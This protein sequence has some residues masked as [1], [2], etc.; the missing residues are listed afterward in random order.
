MSIRRITSPHNPLVKRLRLLARSRE[1]DAFLVEGRHVLA[2]ALRAGWP[3]GEVLLAEDQW[4]LWRDRLEPLA[5]EGRVF[6]A[7]RKVVRQASALASPEG[8][9]AIAQRR[10]SPW[11][12]TEEGGLWLYLDAVQDPVNVGML[13]R[14]G[15]AFGL[16]GVFCGQGSADPFHPTAL[17]RSA[18]AAFHLPVVP[19]SL[20]EFLGWAGSRRVLLVAANARGEDFR[21]WAPPAAPVV[22]ALGNEGRGLSPPLLEACRVRL[23]I[24]MMRGWDSLNVAVAGGLL[25]QHLAR[26]LGGGGLGRAS[27]TTEG[28]EDFP[29]DSSGDSGA[30]RPSSAF[31][32]N[33]APQSL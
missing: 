9:V 18:G 29:E 19:C 5:S 10:P 26:L 8:V 22:L 2:E 17:S 31:P 30:I 14:S 11:P 32:L 7:P 4:E 23:S 15:A 25:M 3:I 16:A 20:E 27:K 24:P 28:A 6:L 21:E 13:V 12:S 1:P 33:K